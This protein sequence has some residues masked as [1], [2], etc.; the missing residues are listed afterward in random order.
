MKKSVITAVLALS[1]LTATGAYGLSNYSHQRTPTEFYNGHSHNA[2]GH[3]SGAPQH[4]GGLDKYGCH[5]GSV[6]YHCH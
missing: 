3:T 1:A 4:S 6:P 5:N 2:E